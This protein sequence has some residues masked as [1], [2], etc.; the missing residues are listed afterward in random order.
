MADIKYVLIGTYTSGK[1][2]G[3]QLYAFDEENGTARFTEEVQVENP[4]YLTVSRNGKYI[5]AVSENEQ[6]P[7]YL[8]AFRFDKDEEKMVFLNREQTYGAA[9]CYVE[10][11][12]TG[13]YA[14]TA[15]Y[16][17]GNISVF[18]IGYDGELSEIIQRV[19]FQGSG[20]K[21][22]RQEAPHLHSVKFSPEGN[23]L[24][25][26]DL[27][28]D[29]IYRMKVN[30]DDGHTYL[31]EKSLQYFQV[32]G[33]SGPRHLLFHPSAKYLYVITELSGEVVVFHYKDSGLQEIQTVK[34]DHVDGNEA[35]DIEITPDGKFL[36][37]SSRTENDGIAIFSIELETGALLKVDYIN[38][39][40]HP[41]NIRVTP[42]SNFLLVANRDSN[43]IEIYKINKETG[44]L[45][46]TDKEIHV[47]K[48]VCVE[49]I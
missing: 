37:A 13:R 43:S 45:T 19:D 15:N 34:I 35:G 17:G 23:Y 10:L 36:Y 11:D 24:F 2:K 25:A 16:A 47:D 21:A 41:R 9:P 8:S 42:N 26:A 4:S 7:C 3:L 39:G 44:R 22:Q 1:S 40:I 38:T 33:G 29:H 5:Y 18:S 20:M 14:V 46:K 28:T 30:H 12:N 48:P 27:G 6:N 32:P 49:F 31:D